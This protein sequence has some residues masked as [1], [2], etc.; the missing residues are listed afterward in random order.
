[1]KTIQKVSEDTLKIENYLKDQNE[2]QEITYSEIA[3]ETGVKMDNRGK[4]FLRTAFKRLKIEYECQ[5]G[6]G[7]RLACKDSANTI[8][9]HRVVKI[10]NA[11]KKTGRTHKNLTNRFYDRL[12]EQEKKF[13]NMVGSWLGAARV[14]ARNG[15]NI[16][17][18]QVKLGNYKNP[19]INI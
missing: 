17:N 2:G 5:K 9:V 3:Q 10:D 19:E 11:V 7:I 15:K 12:D 16:L 14:I 13:S 18:T 8:L 1:M 4:T 6:K